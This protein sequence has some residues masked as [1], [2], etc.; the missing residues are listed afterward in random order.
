MD[1]L[2]F[3]GAAA[4][5]I[6]TA[7]V[8]GLIA[9]VA[10]L[11]I[12]RAS[13]SRTPWA[14][15]L[16]VGLV[17]ALIAF[18]ALAI[19]QAYTPV[20]YG[21][22]AAVARFGGL[23]GTVFEPGLH[24]RTPFIDKLVIVPTLVRSYETSD[25]PNSSNAN[26]TDI[27]VTAQT[28]DGQQ[29][30]IKYTVLFRI[31]PSE[32]VNIVQNIGFIQQVVENVVKAH[33]RNLSRLWAQRYTA[34]ELFSGEGIFA[35]Q[36]AVREAM[37]TDLAR[38][39]IVLDDFLV[40]KVDFDEEYIRA[41]EQQQIAQE[42]IETAS[43]NAEAAEYERDRQIRLSEAEAERTRLLAEADA[44]RQRLLADSEAYSIQVRGQALQEYPEVIQ[45]EFVVNLEGIKWGIL[46][47]DGITP[48]VPIPSFEDTEVV[49]P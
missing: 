11:A 15:A 9:I 28:I 47:G 20:E 30:Q 46:P 38:Y 1:V 17:V 43:Y 22:V 32:A 33:S 4:P 44:E 19:A 12:G 37:A 41:I 40:R 13:R 36:D 39:G 27:P 2:A 49:L 16:V 8:V 5:S 23:T 18:G 26:Y 3:I 6:I 34:E 29:I 21:T 14:A 10:V 25:D 45:W 31:P 24:W 48:L 42:A 7:G 35:Y